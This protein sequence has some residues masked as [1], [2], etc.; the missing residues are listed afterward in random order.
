MRP[1]LGFAIPLAITIKQGGRYSYPGPGICAEC[2]VPR[3][4]TYMRHD[5]KPYCADCI[6]KDLASVL[7]G[8]DDA[9]RHPDTMPV[10][11]PYER[12]RAHGGTDDFELR[13]VSA[14]SH[15]NPRMYD[16]ALG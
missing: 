1:W 2:G 9:Q 11:I 15:P 14:G 6:S 16:K 13:A 7:V 5:D 8:P 4:R 3:A 10:E 12:Y